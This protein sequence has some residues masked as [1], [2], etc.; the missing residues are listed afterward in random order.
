MVGDCKED[1]GSPHL[2]KFDPTPLRLQARS[3]DLIRVSDRV[4][5]KEAPPQTGRP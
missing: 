1:T 4:K 2:P 3:P 5:A